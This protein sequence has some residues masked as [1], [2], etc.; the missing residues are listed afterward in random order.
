M[1]KFNSEKA[2]ILESE[3]R[4]NLL[5]PDKLLRELG[6]K[7]NMLAADIG[8]GTGF[9]TVEASKILGNE[10]KVYAFDID[11]KMLTYLRMKIEKPNIVPILTD[12]NRFPLK[13]KL[14][15]FALLGFV[16]HEAI[17]WNA[18]LSETI[19]VIKHHGILAI[20]EWIKQNED[21]GPPESDRI[22]QEEVLKYLKGLN[23]SIEKSEQINN[24]HYV[25][26]GKVNH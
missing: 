26:M 19:R 8:C 3:E 4:Y 11:S 24:S 12:E 18:F 20:V 2:Q 7:E 25:I 1:H 10:G 13:D 22:S 9:F 17:N 23:F 6:L 14:L 21:S 15:D 16:L 5:T